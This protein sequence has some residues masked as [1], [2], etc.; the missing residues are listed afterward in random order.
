MTLRLLRTPWATGIAIA[1]TLSLAGI[2]AYTVTQ[3]GWTA[4]AEA[5]V[6]AVWL[7]LCCGA[8]LALTRW[9][10]RTALAYTLT[11]SVVAAFET[12]ARVIVSPALRLEAWAG[13]HLRLLTGVERMSGWVSALTA[14]EAVLDT[15]L[16]IA[17]L[18]IVVWN[19]MAWLA[20]W[21]AR[22]QNVLVAVA[23]LVLLLA[24]NNHLSRQPAAGFIALLVCVLLLSASLAFTGQHRD[25]DERGVDYSAELWLEW[26]LSIVMVT[27]SLGLAVA[28]A[29]FAATPAG[30]QAIAKFLEQP[31]AKTAA[32][33]FP[34]VNPPGAVSFAP[35]ATTPDL[36]RIGAPIPQS[37]ETVMW[38][39]VSDPPPLPPEAG[40][41]A[42]RSL[43]VHYWRNAIFGAYT[44][45][46]WKPA[47]GAEAESLGE[48]GRYPLQQQFEIVAD[49]S[50]ALFAV[51]RPI[52]TSAAIN[53][54]S[55]VQGEV[56]SYTVTSLATDAAATRLTTASTLYSPE[57]ASQY[58][59]LP[60]TV[61]ARVRTL[62]RRIAGEDAAPY[63]AA[64]RIQNYLRA[65]YPY[66]LDVPPVPA[67]RDAVDYFLFEAPGGFCTYYASAM[68]V[69]LRAVDVPA[70]VVTGFAMGTFDDERGAWR[71][72]ASASHA[73]VEVYFP[74]YGWVEFEPT[75]AFSAIDYP[76]AAEEVAPPIGSLTPNTAP[77]WSLGEGLRLIGLIAIIIAGLAWLLRPFIVRAPSASEHVR[78][79]YWG[80]RG[81]L[82]RAG[83]TA[84][85][86][87]TPEEYL[88]THRD[89][90]APALH[91]A[92]RY[93]TEMYERAV[94]GERDPAMS[95]T[96]DVRRLWQRARGDWVRLWVRRTLKRALKR[97]SPQPP[98]P[99]PAT[100]RNVAL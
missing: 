100:Q 13:M 86:S 32:Q 96:E 48:A 66:Q 1:L 33:L 70:R 57:V 34:G 52:T 26:G 10:A 15:G 30:W 16:F 79:L 93:A 45:A 29:P 59:Q 2:A 72:P 7:G 98:S 63:E 83:L 58:L 97:P 18:I 77:P 71:V 24:L 84:T 55:L 67:G 23:P 61:P 94:Y 49:H 3:A 65:N 31:A 89:S 73:W 78:A 44:G 50:A 91:S 8:L 41:A 12:V 43:R 46:G 64:L 28:A 74:E 62:A 6:P 69:M 76:G 51:N 81:A 87:T 22:H 80:M 92:L 53:E 20:W 36:N 5:H 9:K 40:E 42:V 27:L 54:L 82:S 17:L 60:E 4:H 35:Y 14:G 68:V 85:A 95:E 21:L 19:V 56:S 75:A 88:H 90:L 38:V 37:E 25:W 11:L 39:R 99:E 47:T